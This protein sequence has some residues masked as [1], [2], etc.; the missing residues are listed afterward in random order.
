MPANN[1]DCARLWNQ[2]SRTPR[3]P[4]GW[5][6]RIITR[7]LLGYTLA[8]SWVRSGARIQTQTLEHRYPKG[9]SNVLARFEKFPTEIF[10]LLVG[11]ADS[12]P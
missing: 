11:E 6:T 3:F 1:Q 9:H 2:E 4:C 8:E 10:L 7:C 12:G 5:Q